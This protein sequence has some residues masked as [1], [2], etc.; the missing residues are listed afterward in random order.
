LIHKLTTRRYIPEDGNLCS[1]E[2]LYFH[3]PYIVRFLIDV[4]ALSQPC[5]TLHSSGVK[6]GLWVDIGPLG[7]LLGQG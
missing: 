7:S 6:A 1:H 3:N 4:K 2:F 5:L